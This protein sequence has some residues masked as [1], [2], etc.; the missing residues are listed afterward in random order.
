MT[1]VELKSLIPPSTRELGK[2]VDT[3]QAATN[4]LA[5]ERERPNI[6]V[7]ISRSP[8]FNQWSEQTRHVSFVAERLALP[9][10]EEHPYL[11]DRHCHRHWPFNRSSSS[12]N[13]HTALP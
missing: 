8:P 1:D 4:R 9:S 11:D 5:S 10:C 6:V 3:T 13:Y 2:E 7:Q 12:L